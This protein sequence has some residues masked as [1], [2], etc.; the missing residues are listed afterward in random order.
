MEG[1]LRELGVAKQ[2]QEDDK[3]STGD[4]GNKNIRE[5]KLKTQNIS[6]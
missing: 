5:G 1:G 2:T 4:T 6:M 3:K